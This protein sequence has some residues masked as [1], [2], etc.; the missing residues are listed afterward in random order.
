MTTELTTGTRPNDT[1]VSPE[2]DA[3]LRADVIVKAINANLPEGAGLPPIPTEYVFRKRDR[4]AVSAAFHAAFELT[5]GAAALA[6]WARHEPDKFY[7]LFMKLAQSETMTPGGGTTINVISSI[8]TTSLDRVGINEFGHVIEV[9][10]ESDE[11][12]PD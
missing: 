10:A 1:A 8:P 3:Y 2:L 6:L 5:G 12:L 7:P 4:E 11:D 9:G